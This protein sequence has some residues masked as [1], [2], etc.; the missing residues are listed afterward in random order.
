MRVKTIFIKASCSLSLLASAYLSLVAS[1]EAVIQ[2]GRY[3]PYREITIGDP[4][5]PHYTYLFNGLNAGQDNS[6]TVHWFYIPYGW[7]FASSASDQSSALAAALNIAPSS[8]TSQLL[9][10]GLPSPP[11]FGTLNGLI[12]KFPN[13]CK[14]LKVGAFNIGSRAICNLTLALKKGNVN[15]SVILPLIVRDKT[16]LYT[17]S[18]Q[19]MI[20]STGNNSFAIKVNAG[21]TVPV[22]KYFNISTGANIKYAFDSTN[23][24]DSNDPNLAASKLTCGSV[25]GIMK[26]P[27]A[28]GLPSTPVTTGWSFSSTGSLIVPQNTPAGLYQVNVRASTNA[29]ILNRGSS[30]Q[31][32]YQTLYLYIGNVDNNAFYSSVQ[33]MS[34]VYLYNGGYQPQPSGYTGSCPKIPASNTCSA[35][36][37]ASVYNQTVYNQCKDLQKINQTF[38]PSPSQYDL[39]VAATSVGQLSY[40]SCATNVNDSSQCNFWSTSG[41]NSY[42]DSLSGAGGAN[43]IRGSLG[44]VAQIT[45]PAG[46]GN[47]DTNSQDQT[48]VCAYSSVIGPQSGIS[49]K[50][51]LDF[52]QGKGTETL[53]GN[54]LSVELGSQNDVQSAILAAAY[55]K[56]IF[57]RPGYIG[58]STD[59]ESGFTQ[60]P[61][62]TFLKNLADRLAF[63]GNMLGSY[64]FAWRGF[65]PGIVTALGPVGLAIFS[66]YDLTNDRAPNS[67]PGVVSYNTTDAQN[68]GQSLQSQKLTTSQATYY[69]N[70][71]SPNQTS[72]PLTAINCSNIM[73]RSGGVLNK[74]P[75]ICLDSLYDSYSEG[76]RDWTGQKYYSSAG[77]NNYDL[78]PY[79]VFQKYSGRFIP[80]LPIAESASQSPYNIITSPTLTFGAFPGKYKAGP[81]PVVVSIG[82][83]VSP[84]T[85]TGI[86]AALGQSLSGVVSSAS[87]VPFQSFYSCPGVTQGIY[88]S[89]L[90]VSSPV[91]FHNPTNT[92]VGSGY[93]IA[94]VEDFLTLDNKVYQ[95]LP[96]QQTVNPAMIGIGFFGLG[97]A[98]AEASS[99]CAAPGATGLGPNINCMEPWYIGF[100]TSNYGSNP[101]VDTF[102]I[103]YQSN[104][105]NPDT[106]SNTGNPKPTQITPLIDNYNVWRTANNLLANFATAKAISSGPKAY[107]VVN[108]VNRGLPITPFTGGTTATITTDASANGNK[109]V[110]NCYVLSHSTRIRTCSVNQTG[111]TATLTLSS[112]PANDDD[113]AVFVRASSGPQ[114]IFTDSVYINLK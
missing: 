80:L 48:S 54:S 65:A 24:C 84:T 86:A 108:W 13:N 26:L 19:T 60:D 1:A 35:P 93:R 99:G 68:G 87:S 98:S 59:F 14:P 6:S 38:G 7:S 106:P 42:Y 91:I 55:V 78:T 43:P 45:N 11:P 90:M 97:D 34:L 82:T 47:I 111:G 66:A 112:S 105:I 21:G 100:N 53:A 12:Q 8:D 67:I 5:L 10:N 107:N 88:T 56:Q 28:P 85:S 79:A 22:Y 83:N 31:Y 41:Q 71:L 73:S 29:D 39:K 72:N 40:Q 64:D 114:A 113:Y 33:P 94:S 74:N 76:M 58:V 46:T 109:I 44:V 103:S 89:C 52:E 50:L 37:G 62:Y 2:Q 110:Y 4:P 102:Y 104:N 32:A 36:S 95:N 57:N 25:T 17:Y 23:V 75:G 15:S 101:S 20:N 16:A 18:V 49:T 9:F 30:I 69:A 77:N 51:M 81:S 70:M 96:G 27:S 63:R 3:L 92:A 61:Y